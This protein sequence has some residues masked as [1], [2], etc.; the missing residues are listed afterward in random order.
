MKYVGSKNKLA[1]YIVP[2]LQKIIDTHNINIYVEPF[3]GGG[4][5]IDK[6]SC[7]SKYGFD[8]DNIPIS[9]FKHY[10]EKPQDLDI[11][12]NS[13]TKDFYYYIRDN[14]EFPVWYKSSIL[15]FGSYN[16]RVYGGCYGATAQTKN[17]KTRNYYREAINNFKKQLPNLKGIKFEQKSYLDLDFQD[18]LIYCDPPYKNGIGYQEEFNHDL[19]WQWAEKQTKNNIVLVSENEAPNDWVCI[20]QQ[21][22]KT[23]MNN[24][25]RINKI[26]KLFIH[27]NQLKIIKEY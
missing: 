21:Q 7:K 1:K 17:G 18:T 8:I 23:S 15:L 13:L 24:R 14:N 9:I 10:I 11:L 5:I 19:F 20:W 27:K 25:H 3:V 4:H 6:I 16:S 2:I 12:P 22:T 26:E